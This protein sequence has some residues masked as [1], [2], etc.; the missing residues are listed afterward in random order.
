MDDRLTRRG[1]LGAV[2]AALS[3][4]VA[5]CSDDTED[6]PATTG[7]QDDTEQRPQATNSVSELYRSAIDSVASVQINSQRG[8]GEGTAWTYDDTHLITNEHVVRDATETFV[9]YDGDG[10]REAE[11]VGMDRNSDLAVIAVDE[12]PENATPLPVAEE[13]PAVGTPVAAIGNPFGRQGSFTTGVIS[14]RNRTV[15]IPQRQF[16][17]SP[18]LQTDAA[19]NPG[20]SGGPLLNYDGSVVGVVSAGQGEGLGFAIPA[21][22]VRNVI[23]ALID[24]GEYEYPYL[25]IELLSVTPQLI[26]ANNLE[27]TFGVYVN[28]VI[29]G[30]P[31][32]GVLQGGTEGEAGSPPTGGDIIVRMNDMTIQDQQDL[33][34][35]LAL[36]TQPGT[37]IEIEI[38]RDGQRQTVPLTLGSRSNA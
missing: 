30:T 34:A 1:V 20:N 9:K 2:G 23:P 32:D 18:T 5:G 14:G 33:S 4:S 13:Q 25:G 7:P 8:G 3:V 11:I 38:V 24:G 37:E 16:S 15:R 36:E 35:F 22:I 29:S 28:S 17:I 6:F 26:Q 21:P 27:V 31:A 19:I 12:Q 10:W